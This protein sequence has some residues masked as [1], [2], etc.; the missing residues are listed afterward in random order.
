MAEDGNVLAYLAERA[1]S[2]AFHLPEHRDMIYRSLD[3]AKSIYEDDPNTCLSIINRDWLQ[4]SRPRLDKIPNGPYRMD[5][6]EEF[7]DL[8][9]LLGRVVGAPQAFC[10]DKWMFFFIQIIIQGKGMINWA[11]IISNCLHVHLRRLIPS[12]N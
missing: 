12:S 4:K 8:I 10:F 9:T 5:F 1:T 11:R 2:K 7:K 3:G 6:Q